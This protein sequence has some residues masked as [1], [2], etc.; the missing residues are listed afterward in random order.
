MSY[1]YQSG[2]GSD[3]YL[4][5]Q[6]EQTVI[7]VQSSGP[8]QQQAQSQSFATGEWTHLP[9]LFGTD[10]GL[11]V[12]IATAQSRFFFAL[13]KGSIARL[14][15]DPALQNAKPLLL[16]E[17]DK[18]APHAAPLDPMRPM[19]P[20]E[21]MKPIEPLEPLKPMLSM[22]PMKPMEMRMG[23]MHMSM[24]SAPQ[25]V[26]YKRFCTQ[27]GREASA[28]DRFCAGCGHRINA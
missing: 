6:Q 25:S 26:S 7:R 10:N 19:N 8:G 20:M 22:Q 17:T 12:Q 1:K 28:T 24:G 18:T 3:I 9:L 27:C 14:D 23:N 2:A 16:Q 21:P 15:A 13:N 5:N 11:V 4:E